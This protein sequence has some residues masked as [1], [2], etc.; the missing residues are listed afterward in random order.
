[1][2]HQKLTSLVFLKPY[3]TGYMSGIQDHEVYT[4]VVSLRTGAFS[5]WICKFLKGSKNF[6][7]IFCHI[8]IERSA[9]INIECVMFL[10]KLEKIM[11]N[12]SSNNI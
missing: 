9:Y 3:Q 10:I 2:V 12:Q 4:F 8:R 5:I 7:I 6:G 1:M 11:K